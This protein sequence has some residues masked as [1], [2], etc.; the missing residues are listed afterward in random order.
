MTRE[1]L[2]LKVLGKYGTVQ[3]FAKA[4]DITR[5]TAARIVGCGDLTMKTILEVCEDLGIKRKDIGE[6]FFP[7]GVEIV[8]RVKE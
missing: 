4:H 8:K 6:Y 7:E 1:K 2:R 3:N 5:Q